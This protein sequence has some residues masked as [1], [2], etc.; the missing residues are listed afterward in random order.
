M[1]SSKAYIT[2]AM[3]ALM[4]LPAQAITITLTP[5]GLADA[6]KDIYGTSDTQ[7]VIEGEADIRDLLRLQSLPSQIKELDM[8]GL[9]IVEYRSNRPLSHEGRS[10]F[11]ANELPAFLFMESGLEKIS[12]PAKTTGIPEGFFAASA[13]KEVVLPEGVEEIGARAFQ[14]CASLSA[15]SFPGKLTTIGEDAFAS[16][17]LESADLSST[18]LK[19]ISPGA[20]RGDTALKTVKFPATLREIGAEAFASTSVTS[21]DVSMAEELDSYSLSQMPALEDV[22][23]NPSAEYGEGVMFADKSLKNVEGSP[24]NVNALTYALSTELNLDAV[25]SAAGVLGEYALALNSTPSM[26]L[27]SGLA[28]V[29]EGAFYG[30]SALTDIDARQLGSSLPEADEKSFRGIDPTQVTLYVENGSEASWSLHPAWGRFKIQTS[31]ADEIMEDAASIA[32]S[33]SDGIVSVKSDEDIIS[34]VVYGAGGEVLDM[35]RPQSGECTLKADVSGVVIVKVTT[36]NS[37]RSMRIMMR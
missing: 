35:K 23:V 6:M 3:L 2:A 33:A 14:D 30:M 29:E 7:L 34:A 12:V 36:E 10:Y 4:S 25:V 18:S 37:S 19:S 27:S 24:E 28:K 16:S 32:I 9:S 26:I 17:G 11:K 1:R 20:F 15:V 21:L 31:G 8:T 22:K 13:L 5:G